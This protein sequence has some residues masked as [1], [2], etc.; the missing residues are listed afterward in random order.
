[1]NL[2]HTAEPWSI[3]DWPQSRSEISIGAIGTPR[4]AIIPLRD[5]SINEQKANAR[6]IVACVNACAGISAENL[7][8]NL[9]VKELALRYNAVLQQRDE[10]LA[11]LQEIA[12]TLSA[13]PDAHIG[14]K[15]VH[16]AHRKALA[17]IANLTAVS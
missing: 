1:M 16:F 12:K 3:N 10:T 17:A 9:P 6:R 5:V 7:E 4:V 13:H 11:L 2:D 14:N 15:I 8:D